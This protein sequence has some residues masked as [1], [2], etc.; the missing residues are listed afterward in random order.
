MRTVSLS[1]LTGQAWAQTKQWLLRPFRWRVWFKL[2]LIVWLSGNLS[3]GCP[4]G[5]GGG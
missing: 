2:L 3:G 4:L 1:A 5:G